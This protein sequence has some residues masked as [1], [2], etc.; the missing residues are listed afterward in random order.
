MLGFIVIS[1]ACWGQF[2]LSHYTATDV[3]LSE[4][5]HREIPWEKGALQRNTKT[6]KIV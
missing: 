5:I 1:E 4:Q 6:T 3:E 2:R